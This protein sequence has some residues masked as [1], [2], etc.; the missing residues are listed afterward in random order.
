M[1]IPGYV[2]HPAV[3][4]RDEDF[5]LLFYNSADTRLTFVRC[6]N[7][8]QIASADDGVTRLTVNCVN[9]KDEERAWRILRNLTVKGLVIETGN[10]L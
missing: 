3:R 9:E 8:I 7:A 2:V 6:G 10:G 4:V 1:E 5:G